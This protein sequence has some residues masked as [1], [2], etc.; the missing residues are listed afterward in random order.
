MESDN[1][2][3]ALRNAAN[4]L[5]SADG[6]YSILDYAWDDAETP[7]SE[8]VGLAMWT[9]DAPFEPD[10]NFWHRTVPPAEP[11]ERDV[12]FHK[13]GEDFIGTMELARNSIGLSRYAWEH[14]KP[15]HILDDEEIFWEHRAAATLWLNIAS[16]R[17]R[18]YF[19]M[20]RF[21]MPTK[22]Y[23]TLHKE[24]GIYARQ[25]RMHNAGEGEAAR[26]VALELEPF[27]EQ[28]GGF[29]RSRNE[30]V[31]SIASR[32]GNNA[33]LSL[34]HQREQATQTPFV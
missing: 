28:L 30:I 6:I 12:I 20:A 25:F 3:I 33:I 16:D 18:D 1:L 29:R 32:Q 21:G 19:V 26:K 10:F 22:Q 9:T 31:H 8:Y 11:T 14:R 5:L 15:D 13:S 34:S 17:I 4:E 24:N 23:K 27:A 2:L 7:S